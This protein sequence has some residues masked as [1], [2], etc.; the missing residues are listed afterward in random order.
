MGNLP[1]C[2]FETV[3]PFLNVGIDY[4]GPLYIRANNLRKTSTL[5]VYISLFICMTTKWYTFG[6]SVIL[7]NS[8]VLSILLLDEETPIMYTVIMAPISKAFVLK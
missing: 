1:E 7:I 5:K 8:R 6:I 4:G 3:R 2:R